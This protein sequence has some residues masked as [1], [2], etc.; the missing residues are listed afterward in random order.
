MKTI[1]A[2]ELRK[3]RDADEEFLLVNTLDADH[4]EKTKIPG[5]VSI[6]QNASDFAAQ[7]EKRVGG[8][9]RTVVVYCANVRCDSST[10]GADKLQNAG[11]TNVFDFADGYE[12]WQQINKEKEGGRKAKEDAPLQR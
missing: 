4:F 1:T 2:R 10:Q 9:N 5:A 8:K 3:M 7:I 6:P 12:G 11:F